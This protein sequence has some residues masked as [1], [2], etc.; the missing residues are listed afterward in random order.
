MSSDKDVGLKQR[1]RNAGRDERAAILEDLPYE[2]GFGKPPP[3]GRFSKDN[4]PTRRGRRK[5]ARDPIS[6]LD[7]E[8]SA[9]I[10]VIDGGRPRR[11]SKF[12]VGAR[13]FANSLATGDSKAMAKVL[14]HYRKSGRLGASAF[15]R[16]SDADAVRADFD[17]SRQSL[18]D[19]LNKLLQSATEK[20]HGADLQ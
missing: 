20:K 19:Q 8:L 14:D 11:M 6:I 17:H 7:E 18:R 12:R 9:T 13:Q 10:E 5:R 3:A 1:L 16:A 15:D 4:Q 2:V